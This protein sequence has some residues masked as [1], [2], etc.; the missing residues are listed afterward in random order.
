MQVIQSYSR[1]TYK[2]FFFLIG[3]LENIFKLYRDS[4]EHLLGLRL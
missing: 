2:N 3:K 4:V 1:A